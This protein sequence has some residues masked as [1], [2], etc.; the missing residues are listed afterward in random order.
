MIDAL[1]DLRSSGRASRD[2][3]STPSMLTSRN[4]VQSASESVRTSPRTKMP[5]LLTTTSARPCAASTLRISA[6]RSWPFETSTII[7][8][9]S[10]PAALISR[11][12]AS[13]VSPLMSVTQTCAPSLAKRKAIARPMPTPAPVITAILSLSLAMPSSCQLQGCT[14]KV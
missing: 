3:R 13:A 6:C 10:P 11:T 14:H 8:V 12:V 9:A 4:L 5:A 1:L 2:K 7:A